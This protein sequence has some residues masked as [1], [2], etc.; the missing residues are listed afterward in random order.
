MKDVLIATSDL[1]LADGIKQ[2]LNS[3]Y[4]VSEL[5]HDMNEANRHLQN[6]QF[7][8]V[9]LDLEFC[10]SSAL[11]LLRLLRQSGNH[12]PVILLSFRADKE[13]WVQVL[14]LG[15]NDLLR[16]PFEIDDLIKHIQAFLELGKIS[17]ETIQCGN[18][19]LNE[20]TKF[21]SAN[22]KNFTI[23]PREWAIL[24]YLMQHAG[25]VIPKQQL[26]NMFFS[27]ESSANRSNHVELYISRIRPKLAGTNARIRTIRGFGYMMEAIPETNLD[28]Y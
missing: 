27:S 2:F 6:F 23:L 20:K 25:N 24:K 9:V 11:K 22:G 7:A 1:L 28:S 4:I 26:S 5:A 18:L 21:V 12:V 15:A 16:K 3:R 13:E 10:E 17:L 19:I 8:V 14:A